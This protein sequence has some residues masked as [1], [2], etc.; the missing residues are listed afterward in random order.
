[1]YDTIC[2][3]ISLAEKKAEK[4][5]DWDQGMEVYKG[6]AK[7]PRVMLSTKSNDKTRKEEEDN[8]PNKQCLATSE[9]V[10][11]VGTILGIATSECSSSLNNPRSCA[12]ANSSYK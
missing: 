7:R 1:M 8:W 4:K 2:F 11:G 12:I 3:M 9:A 5:G 6:H 10:R